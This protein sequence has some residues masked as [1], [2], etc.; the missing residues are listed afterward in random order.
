MTVS[1]KSPVN[2]SGINM[3]AFDKYQEIRDSIYNWY[4]LANWQA[5]FRSFYVNA[6]E[7]SNKAISELSWTLTDFSIWL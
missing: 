7:G 5:W 3:Q 2:L 4:F 6:K 1:S